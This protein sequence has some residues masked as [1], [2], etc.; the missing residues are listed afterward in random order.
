MS[1][2]LV[3]QPGKK[4]IKELHT[5]LDENYFQLVQAEEKNQAL[6]LI[7]E[8][9]FDLIIISDEFP[10]KEELIEELTTEVKEIPIILISDIEKAKGETAVAEHKEKGLIELGKFQL[11]FLPNLIRHLIAQA[12]T[13]D[14]LISSSQKYFQLFQKADYG[15]ILVNEKSLIEDANTSA[16]KIL[17]K[18][19]DEI[20]LKPAREVLKEFSPLLRL[21]EKARK[22]KEKE[23]FSQWCHY[24]EDRYLSFNI[25]SFQLGES[26]YWLISIADISWFKEMESAIKDREEQYRQIFEN[27]GTMILILD[28]EGKII[29]ANRWVEKWLGVERTRLK[30]IDLFS[31]LEQL[32]HKEWLERVR[33]A[34][35]S[36]GMF[37]GEMEIDVRGKRRTVGMT[38]SALFK[39]GRLA[40]FLVGFQDITYRKRLKESQTQLQMEL[41]QK[42]RLASLG[43]LVQGIAHNLNNPLTVIKS[44]VEFLLDAGDAEIDLREELGIIL[45]QVERMSQILRDLMAKSRK[46]AIQSVARLDLNQV[47]KDEINLLRSQ[48]FFKHEVKLELDLK[49]LPLIR[50]IYSDFSQTFSNMIKNALD[51]MQASEEKILRI[52]SRT[53]AGAIIIEFEDTGEGI[54]KELI[55][56]L[57]EPFFTTKASIEEEGKVSGVGLGL[58]ICKLLLEPYRAKIEVKSEPGKG[59]CFRILIPIQ[60]LSQSKIL[61]LCSEKENLL[62]LDASLRAIGQEVL[63]LESFEQIIKRAEEIQ[64]KGFDYFVI[65]LE[66][67]G[68]GWKERLNFLVQIEPNAGWILLTHQSPEL[69]EASLRLNI[70]YLILQKPAQPTEISQALALIEFG[71]FQPYSGF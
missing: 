61:V 14:H 23:L 70:R 48:P 28:K 9:K 53:E 32:G 51:A 2:I 11:N 21:L 66:S 3:A 41:I 12:R 31:V 18:K 19:K 50:G 58:Y 56:R 62:V 46:E 24:A 64:R 22:D 8:E 6:K 1:R 69:L 71:H 45:S 39:E 36:E 35:L 13:L 16:C 37:R 44:T 59:S 33:K 57:F 68:A 4:L 20:L 17:G 55:P 27:L 7:S 52:R 54:E 63:C 43:N 38:I 40:G 42:S 34:V 65:D 47:L 60:P 26:K 10:E 29:D 49:P 15:L 5:L 25:R 67:L 30:G